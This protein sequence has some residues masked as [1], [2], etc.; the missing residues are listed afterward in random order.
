M[1]FDER[2]ESKNLKAA[3]LRTKENILSLNRD[4]LLMKTDSLTNHLQLLV[5]QIQQRNPSLGKRRFTVFIYRTIVP[6]AANY[7]NGIILVNLN[8]IAKLHKEEDIAFILCHEMGHD[9]RNHVFE[10]IRKSYELESDK[11][12]KRQFEKIK[13]QEFNK[14]KSYEMY[15][16]T[17]LQKYTSKKRELEVQADSVGLFLFNN[18][19]YNVKYGYETIQKLDSIDNEIYTGKIDFPKFFG[20]P[21]QPFNPSWLLPEEQDESIGGNIAEVKYPDSLKTHPDCKIRLARMKEVKLGEKAASP[22]LINYSRVYNASQLEMLR[23]YMDE[24]ELSK[25]LYNALQLASLYPDNLYL[26]SSIADYLYELYSARA[27]HY[28][29]SVIDGID[30]KQ[31]ESYQ[32]LIHFLNN[33]NSETLKSIMLSYF[34]ANFPGTISDPYAGYVFLLFKNMDKTREQKIAAAGEYEKTFGKN[35]YQSRLKNKFN[36]K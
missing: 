9:L 32:Q 25:G 14:L 17:Y 23:V 19:G 4:S 35:L 2:K 36:L 13:N 8:L 21:A 33:V 1:V 5:N 10:G 29:S 7:G 18:A 28:Y 3:L 20:F 30:A 27:N 12:F 16:A 26:K 11:E 34:K 22:G 6:N 24:Y 15:V 31:P